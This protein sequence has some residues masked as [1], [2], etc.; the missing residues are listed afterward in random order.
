[1]ASLTGS[2]KVENFPTLGTKI[3]TDKN[4]NFVERV[5]KSRSAVWTS[6]KGSWLA[7][8]KLNNSKVSGYFYPSLGSLDSHEEHVKIRYAKVLQITLYGVNVE[9]F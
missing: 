9:A 2:I 8:M 1:M 3:K 4:L 5:M 6:P 7:Y